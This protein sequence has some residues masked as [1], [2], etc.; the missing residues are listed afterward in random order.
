M[1]PNLAELKKK[2]S[3]LKLTV[4]QKGKREAKSDYVSVLRE[5]FLKR[6]YPMGLPFTELTPMLCFASWNLDPKELEGIW[7]NPEWIAQSKENGCR[8]TLYFVPG[9]GVFATSR[10]IS[11]K[12][13]R[14]QELTG[15]LLFAG[16]DKSPKLMT[17]DC[18]VI[19][20]KPIDTTP[21]TAKGQVT[22]SSLHSTTALLSLEDN[23]SKKCQ[24]DQDAPLKFKVLDVTQYGED[25]RK[26]PLSVRL[27]SVK[28]FFSWVKETELADYFIQLPYEKL[29]KK[30]YLESIWAAGGEG[31]VLKNLRANYE[32][33][34][35]RRRDAWVKVKKRVE[36]DCFV[37]GFKRG[38]KD[39]GYENLVGA[40]EFSV[41]LTSGKTHVLGYPINM[42][43]EER[44]RIS[45]YD[46]ETDAVSLL[47]EMYNKVAEISGQDISAR[48]LRL[49]HC[50]LDRWRDQ[51]GDTK[52]PEECVVD[53]ADL[54][55]ASEWVG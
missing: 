2:C 31:V 40:L 42:T 1:L 4:T 54:A 53:M 32:D 28:E 44:Q 20:E 7:R 43:L 17:I 35:S 18:E 33:S 37:T 19:V 34:S 16:F 39:A 27:E 11:V 49:S 6:D 3:T 23:N 30:K 9:L 46:K 29:D 47:P 13:F 52:L 24:R 14:L 26:Q 22:K 12:T 48:E 50:T 10:T 25:L 21:Y 45:V 41:R 15:K 8:L 55:A 38:E 5:H 36:F 51:P